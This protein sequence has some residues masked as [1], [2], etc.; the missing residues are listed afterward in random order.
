MHIQ[1]NPLIILLKAV[2]LKIFVEINYLLTYS[3]TRHGGRSTLFCGTWY[4][5]A[6]CLTE[7]GIN[8][9][10]NLSAVIYEWSLNKFRQRPTG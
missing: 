1:L 10:F 9:G 5:G 4:K 6:G 2:L 3:L 7:G 8:F